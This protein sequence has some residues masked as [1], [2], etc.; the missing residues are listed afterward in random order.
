MEQT[1][2]IIK[3]N[4]VE[5]HNIGAIITILEE[6]KVVIKNIKMETLG[7][8]RAEEFY[9]IHRGKPYFLRLIDFMTSGPVVELLLEREDCINFIRILIGSTDPMN[10]AEGTIRKLYGRNVTQNAAH[11]SDSVENAQREIQFIFNKD[12]FR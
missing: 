12:Y 2:L 3:P 5:D 7:R 11:A 9:S 6:N 10:A 4:A 1:L 8:D